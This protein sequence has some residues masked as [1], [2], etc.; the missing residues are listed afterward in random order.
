MNG[1]VVHFILYDLVLMNGLKR[2]T[3]TKNQDYLKN[4]K[5]AG[6]DQDSLILWVN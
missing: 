5:Q 6:E 2:M 1:F 4:N 3:R